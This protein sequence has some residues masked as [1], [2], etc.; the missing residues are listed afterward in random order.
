MLKY[1]APLMLIAGCATAQ[2]ADRLTDPAAIVNAGMKAAFVDFD[3]VAMADWFAPD[4]IQHN[5]T[6]PT[7][8]APL[9]G[10]VPALKASGL[11]ADVHRTIV[12]GNLVALHSTYSNAQAFGGETLV[13]FDV[14]RV[15]DGKIAEHWDNITPLAAP[16]PSGRTQTDGPTQITDLDKTD[17]NKALVADFVT[18]VL[19][20]GQFDT[21][22]RYIDPDNYIQHNN[23]IG[24]GLAALGAAIEMM[25]AQGIT[26]EYR[27]VHKVIGQGN[28][29][30][31]LSEGVL[32]GQ[33]TAYYDLFRVADGKIV[34]HWDVISP[35]PDQMAH[36]NGKF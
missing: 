7:G 32:G 27:T 11:S 20:G 4:Y 1:L 19:A 16:N 34:E 24:D 2:S 9:A 23:D 3:P 8:L 13:A 6:V 22:T 14:Y 28:F 29:V 35:I 18:N 15:E 12:D 25:A 31:A 33:H 5:P 26:M 10:F 36:Q 30:L 21:I 17:A